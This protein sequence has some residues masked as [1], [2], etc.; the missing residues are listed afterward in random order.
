MAED[1]GFLKA[2][3]AA[4]GDDA[5]RLVYADWLE[6]RGDPRGSFLRVQVALHALAPDHPNRPPLEHDLSRSRKGQAP[7]WLA[8]VESERAH[9]Y[10]DPPRRP[11]CDC[12]GSW[13]KRRRWRPLFHLEPQDTECPPWR[14]L[15]ELV[16]D[17]VADGRAEFAPLREMAPDERAQIVTLPPTIARL[18]AVRHLYLYGSHLVRLP[19]EVGEMTALEKFTPYT[20]YRL[21]WFPYEI[22]R[23]R[24]LRQSTVSTRAL[25]GNYKHRPPFP[26]LGPRT[27]AAGGRAPR[28]AASVG[29]WPAEVTRPCSVC[30]QPFVDRQRHRVWISL[31]VATDVLPLLVNA[32]SDDCIERLPAPPDRYVQSPHRGGVGLKQPPPHY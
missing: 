12:F 32:C 17:A 2:I 22:T 29:G 5:L 25:Y 21:H 14:R 20:S 31:G 1:A 11:V 13:Y 24:I 27:D 16:E 30:G 4:P 3:E 15:L 26:R 8:I 18:K 7:Y 23:C 10:A 6:E 9:L 19:A 28:G